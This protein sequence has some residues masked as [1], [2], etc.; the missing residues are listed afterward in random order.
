MTTK[1]GA[2]GKAATSKAAT[3][4][5]TGGASVEVGAAGASAASTVAP[6]SGSQS[7]SGPPGISP[8]AAA[9][10]AADSS[11][12]ASPPGILAV[13]ASAPVAG[14]SIVAGPLGTMAVAAS[15]P[16]V[17]SDVV[18]LPCDGSPV[19]SPEHGALE[20]SVV[21][22]GGLVDGAT[23]VPS[24]ATAAGSSLAGQPVTDHTQVDGGARAMDVDL[25][26]PAA[27]AA[28]DH[29][30]SDW[31]TVP[32]KKGK[33]P[34]SSDRK[35]CTEPECLATSAG[36]HW[37][38]DCFVRSPE[39]APRWWWK[40]RRPEYITTD[41]LK[42]LRA[43]ADV[44]SLWDPNGY[45]KGAAPRGGGPMGR[46]RGGRF[47]RLPIGSAYGIPG[48]ASAPPVSGL[49]GQGPPEAVM[50]GRARG[51]DDSSLAGSDVGEPKR[52][53]GVYHQQPPPPSDN[54]LAGLRAHQHATVSEA[55]MLRSQAEE[56]LAKANTLD[57]RAARLGERIAEAE[58]REKE[59][60]AYLQQALL[61]EQA[62]V[63]LLMQQQQLRAAAAP[64]EAVA[65]PANPAPAG[66]PLTLVPGVSQEALVAMAAFF[67]NMNQP[68]P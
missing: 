11:R 26:V 45:R 43:E 7:T 31:T 35:R 64:A 1:A 62:K 57:L 34:D 2:R 30:G 52:R 68:K 5:A 49:W 9:A 8:A 44:D 25:P 41:A 56:L 16:A 61:K 18:A 33:G 46:G 40:N 58:A 4:K 17:G 32:T 38:E 24:G 22:R 39:L 47:N 20:A 15:T 48:A 50:T 42:K 29:K 14:S 67:A 55:D 12:V 36:K 60:P 6:A 63:E 59:T 53:P 28:N 10:P 54:S 13:A 27:A 19:S 3:A 37:P 65:Q 23:A 66:V 51:R 21:S